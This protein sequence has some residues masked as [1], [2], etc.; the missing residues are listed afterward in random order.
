MV[1]AVTWFVAV[2]EMSHVT[3]LPASVCVDWDELE[4]HVIKV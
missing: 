4:E 3:Q 1:T 2:M